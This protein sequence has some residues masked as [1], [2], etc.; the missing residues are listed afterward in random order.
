[1]DE[2]ENLPDNTRMAL[3]CLP[4]MNAINKKLKFTTE[5]PEEFPRRRL[6][7][8]DF[9]LWM[10]RGILYHFYFE[11]SMKNQYTIMQRTAMSEHRRCPSWAMSWSAG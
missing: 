10:V 9:V 7:T 1:M 11:K 6:P 8:L 5:S 4:A 3:R 2:R